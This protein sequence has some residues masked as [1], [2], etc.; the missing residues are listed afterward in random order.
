MQQH[1][2]FKEEQRA[3]MGAM[4]MSGVKPSE[5]GDPPVLHGNIA[6]TVTLTGT[7]PRRADEDNVQTALKPLLDLLE[8]RHIKFPREARGYLGIIKN[9][10]QLFRI[11]PI[12]WVQS[13][14]DCTHLSFWELVDGNG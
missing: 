8:I 13:N 1:R 7:K 2:A 4:L 3:W 9:D 5:W 14:Y 11:F 10:K 6:Y 12:K